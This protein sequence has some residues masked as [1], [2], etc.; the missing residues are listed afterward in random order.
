M[1]VMSFQADLLIFKQIRYFLYAATTI[2]F[3]A[4]DKKLPAARIELTFTG[5]D[6]NE[7]QNSSLSSL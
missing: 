4:N 5:P 7:K 3:I 1:N 6:L 2:C